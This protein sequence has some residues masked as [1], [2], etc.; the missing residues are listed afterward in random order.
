MLI[1]LVVM[2]L[3]IVMIIMILPMVMNTEKM[4]ALKNFLMSLR[5]YYKPIR[6]DFSFDGRENNYMEYASRRDRYENLSPEEYI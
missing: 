6:T 3:I 1:V 4:E 5:D 2:I